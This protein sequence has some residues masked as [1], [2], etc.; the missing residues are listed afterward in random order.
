MVVMPARL[1]EDVLFSIPATAD[2]HPIQYADVLKNRLQLAYKQVNQHMAVQQGHLES[3]D[4][5][6]QG[7]PYCINDL[8]FLHYP[9]GFS[10][11]TLAGAFQS[12]Q[13]PRTFHLQDCG[14]C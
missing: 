11:Q 2:D 7:E 1:P 4:A 3:Y 12:G 6:V 5:D 10:A 14:L 8:V 13:G 9:A